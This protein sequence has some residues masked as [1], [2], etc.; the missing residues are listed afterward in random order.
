M[1]SVYLY[2]LS[3]FYMNINDYFQFNLKSKIKLLQ[4]D[5]NLLL[6]RV[7]GNDF[8]VKLFKIYKFHVEVYY[9]KSSLE[10]I[11]V[12]PS[13]NQDVLN[14]YIKGIDINDLF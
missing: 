13:Q 10:V 5:G 11:N 1:D 4:K 2:T 12:I 7:E 14:L 9:R 8:V 3:I 6:E